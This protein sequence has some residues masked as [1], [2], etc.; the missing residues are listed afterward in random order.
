MSETPPETAPS[1]R[2]RSKTSD[3]S[4]LAKS[5]AARAAASPAAPARRRRRSR[6]VRP[7]ARPRR[8]LTVSAAE[9]DADASAETPPDAASSAE[10]AAFTN[11]GAFRALADLSSAKPP[12][13]A[14]AAAAAAAASPFGGA[15]SAGSNPF[16]AAPP[17]PPAAPP[18]PSGFVA[19]GADAASFPA[20]GDAERLLARF[21]RDQ[22]LGALPDAATPEGSPSC[23]YPPL[24]AA[25][26]AL[27][28][29]SS[30]VMMGICAPDAASGLAALRAWVADLGL[31][32]GK[33]HGMD[34]DGVPAEPPEGPVFLKYNSDSGDAFLS[35]YGGEYRGVLFTPEL[36]DG[37]FRQYG[38]LPLELPGGGRREGGGGGEDD[39]GTFSV[40]F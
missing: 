6:G 29:A 10:E 11:E 17:S 4:S 12:P 22:R 32:R 7:S 1:D 16:V 8:A 14:A 3:M 30:R 18:A 24:R 20:R 19:P 28:A 26:R 21:D 13:A 36:G 23:A 39:G 27:A 35:G 38:Y 37:A 9:A 33:L 5:F 15:A 40:R 34:V 31:P 2:A 25:T